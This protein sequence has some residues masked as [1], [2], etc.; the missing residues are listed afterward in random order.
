MLL[1]QKQ[2]ITAEQII[3]ILDNIKWGRIIIVKEAG[4]ILRI[5]KTEILKAEE[6]NRL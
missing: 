6:I 2:E 1:S 3:A 5:E 4:R